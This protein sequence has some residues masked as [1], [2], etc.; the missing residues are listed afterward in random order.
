MFVTATENKLSPLTNC[1]T[2]VDASAIDGIGGS[3]YCTVLVEMKL[4]FAL[5][6]VF[7]MLCGHSTMLNGLDKINRQFKTGYP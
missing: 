4:A 7:I 1:C 5:K 2:V 3:D 6:I